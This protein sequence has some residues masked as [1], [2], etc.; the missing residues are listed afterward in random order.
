MGRLVA[1]SEAF[2]EIY[3]K[4]LWSLQS[5]EWQAEHAGYESLESC[6]QRWTTLLGE[7]MRNN[8]IRSVVDFGCGFWSYAKALDW[9][10][11]E[12]DGFDVYEGVVRWNHDQH[13]AP[14][15]RFHVL[16][17]GTRL[18][19]ADLLITKDVLQH[20]PLADVH[21]YLDIFRRNYRFSI[22][23]NGVFPED[24]LNGEIPA[25]DCRSIRLDLAPFAL[26][27]A[28]LQRW[29]YIEFGA[30]VAKEFCLLQG[31]PEAAQARG[32]IVRDSGT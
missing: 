16:E 30:R 23:G 12:Y 20:L 27:C 7:F 6:M 15:V 18:P 17:D 22:I 25:G 14:N 1:A 13:A 5:A 2:T 4:D 19:A 8:R 24:N 31:L 32:A 21:Y 26:P 29:E 9:S 10:G 3:N 11:V 28:V